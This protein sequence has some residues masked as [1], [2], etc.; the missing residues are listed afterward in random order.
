MKGIIKIKIVL[1]KIAVSAVNTMLKEFFTHVYKYTLTVFKTCTTIS[2]SGTKKINK[3][4]FLNLLK[5]F[6]KNKFIRFDSS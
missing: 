1:V 2:N 3:N 6:Y 4:I 5:R